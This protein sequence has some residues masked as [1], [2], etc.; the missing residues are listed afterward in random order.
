M[1]MSA[2]LGARRGGISADVIFPYVMKH[3]GL[4]EEALVEA[5]GSQGAI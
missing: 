4:S 2:A 5:A 1:V 3:L